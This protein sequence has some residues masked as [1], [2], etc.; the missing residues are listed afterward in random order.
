M[1]SFVSFELWS[2][3]V[4]ALLVCV[5]V[6]MRVVVSVSGLMVI[7]ILKNDKN[8]CWN[9]ENKLFAAKLETI[10]KNNFRLVHLSS[11]H[12]HSDSFLL[13]TFITNHSREISIYRNRQN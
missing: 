5:S 12:S 13:P 8:I 7:N 4:C 10:R 1:H 9:Y 3:I 11:L 2:K 6:S